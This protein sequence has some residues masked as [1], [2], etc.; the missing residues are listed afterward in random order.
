MERRSLTSTF[1]VIKTLQRR[2]FNKVIMG[3][4]DDNSTSGASYTILVCLTCLITR[5]RCSRYTNL[6]RRGPRGF[7]ELLMSSV[8]DLNPRGGS[9]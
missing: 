7:G 9:W 8:K 4:I 5:H 6:Y 1:T 2:F 3:T